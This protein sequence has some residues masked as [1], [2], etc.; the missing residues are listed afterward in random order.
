MKQTIPLQETGRSVSINNKNMRKL[1]DNKVLMNAA[2]MNNSAISPKMHAYY[3]TNLS[4]SPSGDA[5]SPAEV[6]NL[7]GRMVAPNLTN[8]SA[9][10]KPMWH[11][12]VAR[13]G[14]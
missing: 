10:H 14:N 13:Q 12:Q 8:V 11:Q 1:I 5:G 4:K 6:V 2:V 7:G 9:P 3:R